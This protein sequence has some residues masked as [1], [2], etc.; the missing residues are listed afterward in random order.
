MV[1]KVPKLI[2]KGGIEVLN[3]DTG[4]DSVTQIE[5]YL[6]PRMGVNQSDITTYS[7]WFTYSYD[8]FPPA[9]KPDS[10]HPENLPSYSV[11]KVPLPTLNENLTCDTLQMLSLIHI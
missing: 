9:T 7:D 11:A 4:P 2:I 8:I 3:V 5:L 6:N 10:P 1:S